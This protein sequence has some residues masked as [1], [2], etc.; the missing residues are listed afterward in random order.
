MSATPRNPAHWL[1]AGLVTLLSA[2]A[3]AGPIRPGFDAAALPTADDVS[4][5]PVGLGF[6]VNFFGQTF[7]SVYVNNNG[8]VTFGRALPDF[9][10]VPLGQLRAAVV[11]PFFA[12]TDSSAAGTVTYGAGP[13]DGRPAFAATWRG[14]SYH[15]GAGAKANDFQVVL[16]D[17]S[18]TGAGNFDAEFNYGRVQWES[19]DFSGGVGGE[20]GSAARVGVSAGTGRPGTFYELPGSGVAGSFLDDATETALART[21]LN[22]DTPGRIV[23]ASRDGQLVGLTDGPP[24]GGGPVT[25]APG[26]GNTGPIGGVVGTPEPRTLALGLVGLGGLAA[27]RAR[28]RVV[29][30]SS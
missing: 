12:D 9:T 10:P 1:A 17:R 23:L 26:G 27:L 24:G 15:G 30:R 2:A 18:D 7:G 13:V 25:P 14:V 20:G 29:R 19:G 3:Q 28:R 5:G 22:S 11:A 16:V 8:N 4:S 6:S 21:M